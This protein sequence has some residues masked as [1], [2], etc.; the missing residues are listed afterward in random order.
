MARY[1]DASFPPIGQW[2]PRLTNIACPELSPVETLH[3]NPWFSVRNRGGYFTTEYRLRQVVVLPVVHK[4]SV[5]M[6][7]VKRPVISDMTLE[8]PA[9]GVEKGEAPAFAASRELAEESGILISDLSR[10]VP[11]PPIAGS[12][13]RMPRLIYVFRVDVSEQEYEE[14]RA[15]D[16][17]IDSVQRIPVRNLAQM[18]ING[19][20]YVA[21]PLAVL[22]IFLS[23]HQFGGTQSIL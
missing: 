2:D 21:V 7:R 12:P 10:Y 18:M 22:G 9:G 15:H 3:E 6:V 23:L 14:R 13:T 20:I 4:D 5:A 8:L 17:E 19:E 16:E 11:M 1:N